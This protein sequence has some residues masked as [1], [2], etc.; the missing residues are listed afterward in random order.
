MGIPSMIR[1]LF[2]VAAAH[3]PPNMPKFNGAKYGR[4]LEPLEAGGVVFL[5]WTLGSGQGLHSHGGQAGQT[6]GGGHFTSGQRGRGQG[7]HSP[8]CPSLQD[9]LSM[10][11]GS[12]F[13]IELFKTYCERSG[14]GGHSVLSI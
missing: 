13:G 4:T 1:S 8:P 9:E 11:I 6:V 12:G 10:I 14:T 7:G 5:H 3:D 2:L